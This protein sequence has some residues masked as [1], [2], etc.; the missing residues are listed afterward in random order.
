MPKT[1]F[2]QQIKISFCAKEIVELNSVNL[3]SVNLRHFMRI[4]CLFSINTPTFSDVHFIPFHL[5]L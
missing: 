2:T 3:L 4:S 5:F 1:S